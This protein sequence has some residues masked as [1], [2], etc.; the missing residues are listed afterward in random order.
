MSSKLM[1]RIGIGLLSIPLGFLLLF[2]LG[3]VFS[4]DWSGLSH[5]IQAAPLILLILVAFKKPFIG[6]L[7]LSAISLIL[8][9]WYALDVPFGLQTIVLVELFLFV[10]PFVAGLLLIWSAKK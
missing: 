4:G 9:T 5:L 3:E 10:P 8:G 2:T 7:L 6:G 1:K